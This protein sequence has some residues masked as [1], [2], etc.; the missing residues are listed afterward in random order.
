MMKDHP[1]SAAAL[2][3]ASVLIFNGAHAAAFFGIELGAPFSMR[4]CVA[5]DFGTF[6]RPIDVCTTTTEKTIHP[7]GAVT[8][9]VHLAGSPNHRGINEIFVTEYKGVVVEIDAVTYGESSQE[10][11]LQDLIT[12]FGPP[13]SFA[14]VPVENAF[15]ARYV[16]IVA[17]WNKMGF[18][19]KFRGMADSRNDGEIIVST[20][21]A[22][23]ESRAADAWRAKNRPS[24]M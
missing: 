17:H 20:K 15:R 16:K 10:Q 13:T 21:Q 1:L 19:V 8:H 5:G 6:N 9:S 4:E 24:K 18:T 23:E 11:V 14:K 22:M 2:G 3:L 12:K 7:W